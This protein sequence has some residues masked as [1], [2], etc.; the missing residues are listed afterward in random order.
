[1]KLPSEFSVTP[2]GVAPTMLKVK[3]LSSASVAE[4]LPLNVVS[5]SVELLT[6][7]TTGASFTPVIVMLTVAV[8]ELAL[9]SLAR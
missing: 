8:L 2:A 6:A 3:L 9:P 4:T 1:M 5:S 7:L